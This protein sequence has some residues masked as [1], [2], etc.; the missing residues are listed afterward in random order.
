MNVKIVFYISLGQGIYAVYI[1]M[2]SREYLAK[3]LNKYSNMKNNIPHMK[4]YSNME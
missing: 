1:K 2:Y 4:R 3:R